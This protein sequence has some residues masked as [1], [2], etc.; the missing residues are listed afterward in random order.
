MA[1]GGAVILDTC[2]L[3]WLATDQK[4]LSRKTLKEIA[5]APAVYVSAI[6]GF[7]TR[8]KSLHRRRAITG[9]SF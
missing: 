5:E 2:G 8:I 3:L 6:S 7:A 1:G 4:K 9:N